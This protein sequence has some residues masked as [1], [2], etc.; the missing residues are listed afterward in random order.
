MTIDEKKAYYRGQVASDLASVIAAGE[1][2][3]ER[4]GAGEMPD[5]RAMTPG[6]AVDRLY[7]TH[8]ANAL[9]AGDID[10]SLSLMAFTEAARGRFDLADEIEWIAGHGHGLRMMLE[11]MDERA[12]QRLVCAWV[13]EDIRGRG[14]SR[15]IAE[16]A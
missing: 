2:T 4:V 15:G 5:M 3:A 14:R 16:A 6:E 1:W 11:P 13:G 7:E 8:N 9:G 12:R 10:D